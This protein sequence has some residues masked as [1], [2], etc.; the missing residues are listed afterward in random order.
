[1]NKHVKLIVAGVVVGLVAVAGFA[2]FGAAATAF[3]QSGT[4]TPPARGYGYGPGMLGGRH[5]PGGGFGFMAEY[6]DV[7]HSQIAEA[8]GLS[9]DEF[10][11][12]LAE[13]K[14][15]FVIAQE[16]G[17]DF[18][19]VQAAMQAGMADAL[20]QAVADGKIT[21]EQANWMISHHAQMQAWHAGGQM[22][23]GMMSGSGWMGGGGMM[24]GWRGPGPN[25]TPV[26]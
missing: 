11:A 26:P 4:P 9:P 21:Q 24:G 13:G 8:L 19:T 22:G 20:Q 15:P 7:I 5:M 10:N 16:K 6:R 2:A 14:T 12:A 18:A 1:M 17:V 3:A 23:P 25:T